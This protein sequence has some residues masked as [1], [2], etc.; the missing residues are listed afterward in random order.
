MRHLESGFI[1]ERTECISAQK[2][3]WTEYRKF[4]G[5]KIVV[6]VVVMVGAP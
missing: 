6:M 1:F 4:F 3:S 5:P 2:A